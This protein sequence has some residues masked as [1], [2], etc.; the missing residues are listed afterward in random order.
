MVGKAKKEGDRGQLPAAE[1]SRGG[2]AQIALAVAAA[3]LL[4]G[5][6]LL[7]VVS[8]SYHQLVTVTVRGNVKT[9]V[10]GPAG[11]SVALI[12]ATL[13]A[14][15]TL[16]LLAAFFDRISGFSTPFGS[17][18]LLNP[19]EVGQVTRSSALAAGASAASADE[20]GQIAEQIAPQVAIVSDDNVRRQHERATRRI[21]Y[22]RS[23]PNAHIRPA[24]NPEYVQELANEAA[25]D[26]TRQ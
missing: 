18:N 16:L 24:P 11:P 9:T 15:V 25:R 1:R 14:G 6:L 23:L 13:T 19:Q 17:V 12:S 3:V 26:L 10:T 2:L 5:T 7:V 4:V 8:V 21:A 20:A 22:L